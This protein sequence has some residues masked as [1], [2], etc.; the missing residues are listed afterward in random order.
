LRKFK[1]DTFNQVRQ[2]LS[3]NDFL[4]YQLTGDFTTNPS[5]A[6]EM[7]LTDI[8]M[9]NWSQEICDIAGVDISQLSPILPSQSIIGRTSKEVSQLIG[10]GEEILVINGGQDHSC[11]ALAAGMTSSG[12]AF[13]ACGTA[14]VINSVLEKPAIEAIPGTMNL[15]FHVIPDRWTV[16]QFLGGLGGCMEWFFKQCWQGYQDG[17][18]K[19]R[20]EMID[21]FNMALEKTRAGCGGLI[22]IPLSGNRQFPDTFAQGSFIGL[23]MDHTVADMGRALMEGAVYELR[24]A[25]ESLNKTGM[26]IKKMFMVGGATRSPY[27]PQIVADVCGLEIS[28]INFSHG[29]ALGAAMLACLGLGIYQTVDDVIDV[30]KLSS[31]SRLPDLSKKEIYDHIFKS[32]QSLSQLLFISR[33]HE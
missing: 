25:L 32:Y 21:A 18:S 12:Q 28:T 20:N 13:L 30:F 15:N 8:N 22:C 33:K 6:G 29:P 17:T 9:G 27:W 11:E 26:P 10:I 4:A 23:R 24:W 19:K 5:M 16:S 1:P 31:K 2:W 14:W 7:L 3:I